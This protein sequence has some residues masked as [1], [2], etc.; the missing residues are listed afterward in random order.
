[1]I[2]LTKLKFNEQMMVLKDIKEHKNL[3]EQMLF[4]V[5]EEEWRIFILKPLRN[6]AVKL[7]F[8]KVTSE[9]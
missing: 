7:L 6:A 2:V 8:L 9:K 1:M 4:S 5:K 3:L